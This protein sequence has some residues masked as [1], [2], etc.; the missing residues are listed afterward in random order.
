M[1]FVEAVF[2]QDMILDQD[3]FDAAAT[4]FE[5]LGIR[6]ENLRGEI[7]EML[8]TLKDGFNTPAGNKFIS[9]CEKS[10]LKPLED[11]KLVLEHISQTLSE[12]KNAYSTVFQAYD[13]LQTTIRQA[14]A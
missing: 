12:S 6:L 4:D 3:A 8:R 2:S 7:D 9:S 13:A 14:M 5:N 10:L 11:Q 1:N